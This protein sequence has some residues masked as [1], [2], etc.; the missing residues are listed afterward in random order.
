[1]AQSDVD[2]NEPVAADRAR[3]ED[4]TCDEA[5]AREECRL[6]RS[7]SLVNADLE[8]GG[9]NEKPKNNNEED[10]GEER[11]R[12]LLHLRLPRWRRWQSRCH[13]Q[14]PGRQ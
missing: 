11:A 13:R 1:M 4:A 3:E 6:D 14:R 9:F 7:S 5:V 10:E 2:R 12:L 8:I